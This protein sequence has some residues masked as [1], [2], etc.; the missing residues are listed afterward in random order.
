MTEL[1]INVTTEPY[2]YKIMGIEK[3]KKGF[4]NPAK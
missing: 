3:R 4:G 2:A 1:H